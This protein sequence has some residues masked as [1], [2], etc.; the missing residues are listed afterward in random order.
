MAWICNGGMAGISLVGA[1]WAANSLLATVF[2][3]YVDLHN[4][5]S[6][7]QESIAGALLP[8]GEA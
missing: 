2:Q 3:C 1:F 7:D 5:V 4:V 6:L 8:F